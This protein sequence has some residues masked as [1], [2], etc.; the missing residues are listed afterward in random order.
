MESTDTISTSAAAAINGIQR[1][2]ATHDATAGDEN[3]DDADTTTATYG[4]ERD[5]D[6]PNEVWRTATATKVEDDVTVR[7][8]EYM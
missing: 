8:E 1:D 3:S 2:T 7:G 5:A 6:A 4:N